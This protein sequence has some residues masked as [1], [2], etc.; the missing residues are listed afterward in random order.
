MTNIVKSKDFISR[1]FIPS[2]DID[3]PKK[4]FEPL[5]SSS[6]LYLAR[7][8]PQRLPPFNKSSIDISSIILKE[9]TKAEYTKIVCNKRKEFMEKHYYDILKDLFRILLENA[10][11][12]K[13]LFFDIE[14][15]IIEMID[16]DKLQNLI[17]LYFKDLGYAC[18]VGPKRGN[19]RLSFTL[20]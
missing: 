20:T 7:M 9:I 15:P 2:G 3:T 13:Q 19:D 18:I 12:M 14:F 5:Q 16:V 11:Q 17:A 8:F 6:S 4:L 10:E 1:D